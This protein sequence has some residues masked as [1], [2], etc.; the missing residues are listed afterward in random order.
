MSPFS[1]YFSLGVISLLLTGSLAWAQLSTAQLSGRVTDES[2]AVLP[3]VTITVTQTDTGF[4][5]SDVTDGNGSYVLTN[6]PLGPYRFE[7]ALQGFRTYVQTGIVLQVGASP[8]LN[9]TLSVGA[10]EESVTVEGAAPLVDVQSSGISDVVQNEEILALPLNGRNAVELIALAGAAVQTTLPSQRVAPGGMGVS[11]AGGQSFGVAYV[12]DGAMH[13]N[14]QD[15]LNLPFPF[16]D[17]LQEFSVA[18]SGLNAQHGMHSGAAVNA[19]TKAGTNRFAGNMFEFLRDKQFNATNPF[20]RVG[21]DGK[22]LDDGLQRNQFGGT[23]GGPIVQ[24]TLFF[25]GAYQGTVVKMTPSENIGFVPTPAMLAG[26]FTAAA[27]P[28]CTGGRQINLGG[29]FVN[30]RIN[31]AQFSPAALNLARRLPTTTD[32]CGQVNYSF[33][34]DSTEHQYLARIDFQRTADDTIFGRYLA[35]KY[36][37]PIP[38][39]ETDSPLSLYDATR[40]ANVLGMD[41]LAHSLAIGD[42]RVFGSN[43][44][45]SLRFSFNRSGVYRLAPETFDPYDIGSDVYSYQPNVGVFI[46]RSAFQVNNPGPSRFT[47]NASQINDDL[48]LV[49]GNHQLGVGGNLAYWRFN[50]LSHARSGGNWQ[51]TGS[52]TGLPLA[53]FLLGRVGRLEHGGPAILP[54]EQWYLGLYAQDTWR[55]T[56][57]LTINGGLRWEPYFGQSVRNGAIYNFVRENFTNNVRSQVFVNAPAGFIYPGDPG[58][59]GGRRGINTQW[60]NFSPRVGLG[61]D[62]NGDG[63]LAVRTSYGLTYDFPNAEYQLINANS[64]PFG[65]RTITEDPPGRFDRP[66][67]HLGGDPH[68]ILTSRDTVFIPYGAFG[69]TDPNLNS[70][71]V[72]QWNV[73]VERQIGSM[74]QVAASYLG[75]YTD[76][77]WNQVAINPGVFLG[78]GPCTLQG[79]TYP[80]CTTNANLNQRRVFSLS[81]ENPAA[82]RLIGNLDVHDDVGTQS[83]RGLKLSFQRRGTSLSLGGSYTLSRCYGHPA[84]QTGGFPQIANGYTNPDDPDFDLGYCDQDRRHIGVLN[85]GIRTPALRGSPMRALLSDWRIAGILNARSGQPIN[86]ITTQDRAFTGI[87]NQ[88]VDQVLAKAYGSKKTPNDWLN[89]A[90]FALPAPGTLGNVERNSLRNPSYWAIDM[91]VSRFLSVGTGRTLEL[92][93]E[94][95]NVLNTFNW[96]PLP[97]TQASTTHAN[98][99]DGAFGRVLTMAG[100]PR[101]LQF[102]IKYGF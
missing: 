46:V 65:N 18:T 89:P 79:V 9:V 69:A 96:G 68:P 60:L 54:S 77:L 40:N 71:R 15:N 73:T 26:D 42:T 8:E 74:W 80:V 23:L 87:Q 84:F 100:T 81:G 24:N 64:P 37:K 102:G 41:A 14:P 47:T 67:A 6:L 75:S 76:R 50:F 3:G 91:A 28:A 39:R 63:R 33:L 22:R 95:F 82:A 7:A 16:P 92:R 21:P 90:A 44:V 72:Q 36:D 45:N 4:M 32:P 48:T 12:L 35:T 61:W 38:M 13:N 17:A 20:S 27:S 11:V 93:A 98:F 83:Y 62:V 43:T 2:G 99:S 57:R 78:L 88:R 59:P 66:Y 55:A 5:R 97:S 31:P 53:D 70:P 29:G 49:R 85:V 94:A 19:V 30:N 58:F 34:D 1:R 52:A 86:V 101:I 25:F 51:F 56:P 10:L